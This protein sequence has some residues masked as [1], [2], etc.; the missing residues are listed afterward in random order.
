[1]AGNRLGSKSQVLYYTDNTDVAY[2]M[3]R[4]TDLVFAGLG[5]N[6]AAPEV[7]APASPPAGV[8][9]GPTPRRFT[10]RTIFIESTTDGARKSL[11]AFHPNSSLYKATFRQSMPAIDSDSTFVSTGR[12]GEKVSF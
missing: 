3:N 8:I 5:D 9:V 4:D 7:Y 12:K 6:T 1:M 11:I 2:I 10:P